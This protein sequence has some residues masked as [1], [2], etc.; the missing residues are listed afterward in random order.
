MQTISRASCSPRWRAGVAGAPTTPPT[1][2]WL[3][4]GDYFDLVA[5]SFGLPPPPRISREEA[6][7]QR[8]GD[9]LSFMRESRRLSNRRLRAG[10]AGAAA[11]PIGQ[12][13]S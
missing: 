9:L 5:D 10:T 11:L 3:K 8:T 13:G 2:T 6:E 7:Q 4:M 1:D 12:P